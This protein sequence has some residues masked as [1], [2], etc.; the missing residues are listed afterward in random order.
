M[1]CRQAQEAILEMFDG[2]ESPDFD[3]HVGACRHCAA[4][5]AGQTAL[6]RRLSTLLAPPELSPSFR[7]AL[8]ERVQREEPGMWPQALPDIVHVATCLAATLLCA[9]LLPFG[10]GPV[11]AAGVL[12]TAATYL[13]VLAA[14]IWLEA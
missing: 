2:A 9:V 6:D 14:R 1:D 13:L 4:F 10:V 11:L 5:L 8:R 12:V 7:S 3:A